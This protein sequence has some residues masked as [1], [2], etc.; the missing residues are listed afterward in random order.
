MKTVKEGRVKIKI[1]SFDK[2]SSK[3]PVF[4]NPAMELN[5][6]L[7]ILAIQQFQREKGSGI[8]VA[9]VF[10]GSGIRGIRYLVE[11]EGVEYVLAND[12]NPVAVEFIEKNSQLNNTNIDIRMEDANILLRKN[13]GLFDVVDIDP[14]GTPSPFIESAGYSLKKDSLLCITATDTS[15]LCGTYKKP[16]IRKYNA[17]PLK[18]E[19]CHENGLRILAGF[20][21]L[22]IAKYKKYI[23]VKL[24]Y[25]SQHYM[26]LYL[27]IGKGA[28]K[29]DESIKK[30]IGFIYHCHNCLF[31]DLE[32]GIL[33]TLPK[34]CPKCN[35]RLNFTGPL[36]IGKLGDKNFIKE[37]IRLLPEKKLNKKKEA[38]KLLKFLEDESEMP[39]TFYDTHKI[40]SKLKV[41]APPLKKVIESLEEKGFKA[42]RSHCNDT[43]IKTNAP[44]SELKK[45]IKENLFII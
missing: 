6:D 28:S 27:K 45:S 40:C 39:P 42:T 35:E 38:L 2:V 5:R 9:D 43:G 23:K 25:S 21:S 3:A 10:A 31:R 17:M 22:S 7:S 29:T 30:N 8:K 12:I 14:F 44:L 37:M 34:K 16:C 18:T 1:P 33:P 36:W 32:E 24:A 20:T 11:I 41:S 26:R 15:S 13:R 4:Y 19:Y